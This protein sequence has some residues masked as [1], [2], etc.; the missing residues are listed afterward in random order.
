MAVLRLLGC[1]GATIVGALR[2]RLPM[3]A[4]PHGAALAG[5]ATGFSFRHQPVRN[6]ALLVRRSGAAKSV[7]SPSK[8]ALVPSERARVHEGGMAGSV[9]PARVLALLAGSGKD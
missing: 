4:A 2:L 7:F 5:T 8:F 3:P 9:A 1:E 6:R